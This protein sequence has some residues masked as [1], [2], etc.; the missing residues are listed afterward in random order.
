MKG[1]RGHAQQGAQLRPPRLPALR[2]Q[3]VQPPVPAPQRVGQ[4]HRHA[5]QPSCMRFALRLGFCKTCTLNKY[6]MQTHALQSHVAAPMQAH[7]P[8]EAAQHGSS[9]TAA[10][11]RG[12]HGDVVP[13]P[14]RAAGRVVQDIV[15]CAVLVS[16]VAP[17][18]V[19]RSVL[20]MQLH[21]CA[22]LFSERRVTHA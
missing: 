2:V 7:S 17:P 9:G 19:S 13:E 12:V 11:P 21:S 5:C 6:R 22:A 10:A 4:L 1:V 20:A 16:P 3:G 8:H 14:R 18:R 15:L